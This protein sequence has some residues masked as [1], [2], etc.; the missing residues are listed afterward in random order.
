MKRFWYFSRFLSLSLTVTVCV[1]P[2]W[3]EA[4]SPK[5]RTDL[6]PPSDSAVVQRANSLLKQMTTDEKIGQMSQIF[7]FGSG[8]SAEERIRAGQLGSVLFMTDPALINRLQHA[9]VD[10]S[11]LHIPLLFGLD[12]IHGFRTIFP[13]PIGMAASWDP[14]MVEKAQSVAAEEA[15][16]AG[17]H[18]T[19][20]P[21]LDIARD[22][23]WGRIIEGAGEDPYLGSAMAVAQV[24]GFQGPYLGAPNHI[25]ACAKHFAGYGAAEGGRDYDAVDI[26]DDQLWNVYFPPFKSAVDAGVGTVMSAYMDLNGIPATGNRWLLR[27]VLRDQWHFRGFV[28]SDSM[29]VNSL[30]THGFAKDTQ[31]AALRAFSAGVNMEMGIGL[32]KTAYGT[33]LP[34]SL[35]A[36]RITIRQLDDAVR[37]IL[38][39]KIRLG[40]FEHPYVDEA[41]AKDVLNDPDHRA[42]A[43]HS[44]ERSSVLL[45]N[46]GGLL[47]L[48]ASRYK[49]IAVLGPLADSNKDTTGSWVFANDPGETVTVLKALQRQAGSETH[50]EYAPGVQIARKFP[51]PFDGSL[52]LGNS[53]W[54][55]GQAAEEFAKAVQ[56]AQ[57]SD[58]AIMI[59]GEAQNMSGESASRS[60][61]ELPGKQ[62]QLL[63]AIVA[64]GK[65]VIVV[66][67]NG[68]PLNI[69][70]ASEH[71]PAILEA[72]YPGSQGGNAIV[73]LLYG[74]AVPGGK[75]PFTWPRD[76]GQVPI[77]YAHNTTH[78]PQ[79]QN[80]RY[81]E[82]ESTP[83]YPF[84]FGLSYATFSFSNLRLSKPQLK[85]D[86]SLDVSVDVENTS[87]MAADEAVQLY[88][89]QQSG[90]SSRPVRE[91]KGF[92]RIA[93]SPHEKKTVQFALGKEDRTYWSGA[94]HSWIEDLSQFDVWVGG[95]S[96]ASLH[97]TFTVIP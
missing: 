45:R 61:L 34:E 95:D 46:D 33:T 44:A 36:G 49:S 57:H 87:E 5:G 78:A 1:L 38:E 64:T 66:L 8:Q 85:V 22:P 16:A 19:F 40:L 96:S 60:T 39:T 93:L 73:N 26:S 80:K 92:K 69:G 79:T 24:R 13:V 54:S 10:G 59:L 62:Q 43:M 42:E 6:T 37:P 56:I 17:V 30:K 47:P 14:S 48:Q 55:E 84:G 21:M 11:R 97:G 25:V 18:W 77:F 71:V 53:A 74:K 31:D 75:L 68:R 76:V 88:L 65:P 2:V 28:V 27:D 91:L 12:V 32:P 7:I 15:R 9:A 58:L 86:E 72:W 90:T 94:T 3:V 52:L 29:A 70:W 81:W 35:K 20:G 41:L 83:L 67:L 51:S 89:H 63:E 23:R 82:E 50:I 4:Q